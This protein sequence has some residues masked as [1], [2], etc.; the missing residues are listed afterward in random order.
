MTVFVDRERRLL[1]KL[2]IRA[3]IYEIIN[4]KTHI[5]QIFPSSIFIKSL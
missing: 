3:G 4:R 5:I 1:F 2:I